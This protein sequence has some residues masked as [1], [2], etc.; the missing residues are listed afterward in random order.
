MTTP[1]P[2][3]ILVTG[4]RDWTDHVL[5]RHALN[6]TLRGRVDQTQPVVLVH[7]ACPRGADQ[8]ADG[9]AT[10]VQRGGLVALNVERHPASWRPGGVLDR[11]AGFR[12]NAEMVALG[13]DVCLAFIKDGSRGA[14][15]TASLAEQ[16]GIP[17]RRW[18]E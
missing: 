15:H 1:R 11:S 16:A 6:E 13:A 4:S 8:Q 10:D 2:Y 5:I 18:T 9:W 7:G 14:S 3:R 17:T 12:R